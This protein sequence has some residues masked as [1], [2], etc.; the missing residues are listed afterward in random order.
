MSVKF[1]AKSR[2]YDDYN[3]D[4]E[5]KKNTYERKQRDKQKES[6]KQSKYY[7]SYESDWY[8]ESRRYRK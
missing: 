8:N 3:E 5:F 6:K 7:D 4:Y 2:K 1:V